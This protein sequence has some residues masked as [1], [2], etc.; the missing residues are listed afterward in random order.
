MKG[1]RK[2]DSSGGGRRLNAGRG[3]CERIRE[4]GQGMAYRARRFFRRD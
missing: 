2:R 4:F 1:V 3:G